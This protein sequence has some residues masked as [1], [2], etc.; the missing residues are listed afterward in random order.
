MRVW[1]PPGYS[2][3]VARRFPV[4]YLQDGQ[5]VFSRQRPRSQGLS[6]NADTTARKLIL[7][8]LIAPIILVAIDNSGEGRAAEYTPVPW[9]GKGGRA[10][11]YASV[12]VTKIKPFID[13]TYRTLPGPETTAVGGSS[14]GGLFSLYA[15][16]RMPDI[17]GGVMVMSPSV[18]WGNG[19]II[20][21]VEACS[22]PA[23]RIWL[24]VGQRETATMRKGL[25]KLLRAL[26]RSGWRRDRALR[27][28]TLRA[29][30]D[31]EGRHDESSWGRR[32]GRALR[33]LFPASQRQRATAV[34][35]R[36]ESPASTKPGVQQE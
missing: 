1:V 32:F 11:D 13:R 16:L 22:R 25:R 5:N 24:D 9:K 19:H 36:A 18:F 33:F 20:R 30:E 26:T 10:A 31:P 34:A 29:S 12:L 3:G 15:G 6:W 8:G 7:D 14:L 21:E 2:D 28:A 35:P 23:V 27:H 4:L 17:F